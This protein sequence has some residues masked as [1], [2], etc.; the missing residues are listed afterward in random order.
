MPINSNEAYFVLIDVT[1]GKCF[2]YIKVV[3]SMFK[4]ALFIYFQFGVF[5]NNNKKRQRFK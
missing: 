4:D 2:V 5:P 1:L 3:Q